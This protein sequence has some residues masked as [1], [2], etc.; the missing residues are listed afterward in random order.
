MPGCNI[1]AARRLTA[2][3]I[4]V[5]TKVRRLAAK[6]QLDW[7][8]LSV[9]KLVPKLAAQAGSYVVHARHY[10]SPGDISQEDGWLEFKSSVTWRVIKGDTT[11]A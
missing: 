3:G 7:S 2:T 8:A 1:T 6:G 11:F 9:F 4:T 10:G 5:G